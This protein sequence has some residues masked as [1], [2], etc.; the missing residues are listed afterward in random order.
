M[1]KK[2][3]PASITVFLSLSFVLI[4]AMI[5]TI[6]EAARTSAQKYYM[7]TALNSAMESLFSEFHR[8]LW[9][10]YRI[11]ALEYRDE[12]LLKEELENYIRPY[13]EARNL[14]PMQV[15]KDDF[16]FS[17]KGLLTENNHLEEE[18]LEYMPS[19]LAKDSIE[20]FG[21][22]ENGTD[23]PTLLSEVSKKEKEA[24]SMQRL[25]EKYALNHK[26]VEYL[27]DCLND[28]D[29]FCKDAVSLHRRAQQ[30]LE[31]HDANLFLHF[32]STLRGKLQQLKHKVEC[33]DKRAEL[34]KEKVEE[35]RSAFEAEKPN[36][37]EDGIAAIEAQLK[38]YDDYLS[39]GGKIRIKIDSFPAQC[40]SLIPTITAIEESV[41]EFNEYVQKERARRRKDKEDHTGGS[42]DEEDGLQ[43]EITA[44]YASTSSSWQSFS[45]P[46]YGEGT[47][48]INKKNKRILEQFRTLG[49]KKLLELLLPEGKECP[50][51]TEAYSSPLF[52]AGTSANPVQI[53]F[54]GE[55]S[56]RYFHSYHKTETGDTIPYSNA[57]GLEV[58]YLLHGKK[59]DYENLS[60]QVASLLAFREAMNFI[61]IMSSTEKRQAV[62]EFVTS[63]LA[64]S[65]N[66]VVIAVFCSF[67]IGI[68]AFAQS[69]LDVKHLLNDERVPLMHT[70]PSWE[71]SVDH[72]LDFLNQLTSGAKSE[73]QNGLSYTDYLR[74]S[75]FSKGILSQDKINSAMLFLMEKNIRTTVKEKE[76]AFQIKNC[77]YF[78]STDA[79]ISSR[80]SLYH[81]GFLEMLGIH[82]GK[83]R[84][85]NLLHSDYKYKNLS[86]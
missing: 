9:E 15:D 47:T 62:V 17:K 79:K 58:E 73:V 77:L 84:Y 4:A 5:L 74:A 50:D 24:E 1:T 10:N 30:R 8:P 54:L 12:A 57:R 7:Q 18:I 78:L 76:S 49:K 28:I 53:G 38:S 64:I 36:L 65:A 27:E 32:S 40:E 34:L 45:V 16:S 37:E 29:R 85:E 60:A 3:S 46:V 68:W 83:A 56:L 43:E 35:L 67:V 25:Q 82:P 23:I 72:L 70:L 66:P 21:R 26:E 6:T 11:Y 41:K 71:V 61:H 20:F 13:K 44:F 14:F 19:L 48:S 39:T 81:R 55:Y 75:L 59:S 2:S 33:Y 42:H 69:L 86:H 52:S 63:F 22:K 31:E 51:N 80:H